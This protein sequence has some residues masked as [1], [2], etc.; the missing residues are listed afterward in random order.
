MIKLT[1]VLIADGDDTGNFQAAEGMFL[2]DEVISFTGRFY[3]QGA[4]MESFG[5]TDP[6]TTAS[7]ARPTC[8]GCCPPTAKATSRPRSPT[9]WAASSASACPTAPR[10]NPF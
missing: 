7:T 4:A 10:S 2:V 5:F 1:N 6:L 3:A 8:A 9:L